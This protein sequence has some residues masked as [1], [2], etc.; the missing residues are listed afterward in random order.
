LVDA[1]RDGIE[2]GAVA[3]KA[4]WAGWRFFSDHL[5][6]YEAGTREARVIRQ[7]L[8]NPSSG[9][10]KEVL[11][12]LLSSDGQILWKDEVENKD[13][14][15]RR[16]HEALM[17]TASPE[18]NELL[19]AISVYE[20]FCRYLQDA[21]DDCLL[22]LSQYQQRIQPSELAGLVGVKRASK[23][24]PDI[25]IEVSERLSPFGEAVRFQEHFS[26]LAE[27]VSSLHWLER[28]LEHHSRIQYSKPPAG[29]A[30]WFD[31]FDDGSCMI[32]TG[33]LRES[34]GRHDDAYVHAFR[35][36]SLWSFA[37]DL[38]LVN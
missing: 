16:F 17:L 10:R 26:S 21:F 11:S 5:G 23:E 38:G 3:R 34:G 19:L 12:S 30:P 13:A 6:I 37:C 29:K 32:R 9:F 18:L 22:R 35:T 1:I 8:L 28:L 27:R 2:S 7:A 15:E 4:G 25:F 20:R 36:S 14:S 31:R 33:Y 24:V